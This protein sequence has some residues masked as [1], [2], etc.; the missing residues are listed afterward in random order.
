MAGGGMGGTPNDVAA[1]V[2]PTGAVAALVLRVRRLKRKG[3]M[4]T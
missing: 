4:G 2:S 3:T 1:A